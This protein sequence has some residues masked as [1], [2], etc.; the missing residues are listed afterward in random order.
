MRCFSPP[1]SI[2]DMADR[3]E[4]DGFL[5][6]GYKSVHIDDCWMQWERDKGGRLLANQ[7]RFPSGIPALAEY[8]GP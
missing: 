5:E 4:A 8:V 6:A 7:T 1:N 3:M 2:Q